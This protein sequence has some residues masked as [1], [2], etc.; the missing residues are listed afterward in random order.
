MHGWGHKR[1]ASSGLRVISGCGRQ[2]AYVRGWVDKRTDFPCDF[3]IAFYPARYAKEKF[4]ILPVGDPTQYIPDSEAGPPQSDSG[5][6]TQCTRQGRHPALPA[7]SALRVCSKPSSVSCSAAGSGPLVPQ[8]QAAQ[9]MRCRGH[10]A[11]CTLQVTAEHAC[12]RRRMWRCWRSPS[13]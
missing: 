11:P 2:E 1:T 8:Q 4:S 12:C 13:T 9:Y 7:C 10:P 5:S 3:Q 6:G